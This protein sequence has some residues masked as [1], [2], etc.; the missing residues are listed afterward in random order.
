MIIYGY[1]V[2]DHFKMSDEVLEELHGLGGRVEFA[3]CYSC[4]AYEPEEAVVGIEIDSCDPLFFPVNLADI[5]TEPTKDEYNELAATVKELS[6]E[7]LAHFMHSEPR[8]FVFST[9]DD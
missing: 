7:T 6:H 1:R 3:T 4:S 8:V 9:T 5:R 2:R